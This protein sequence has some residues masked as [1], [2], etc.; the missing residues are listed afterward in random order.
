[1]AKFNKLILLAR[2]TANPEIRNVN[3]DRVAI[4][5]L[6]EMKPGKRNQQTGEWEND[7]NPMYI[8]A[9]VWTSSYSTQLFDVVTQYCQQG[10]AVLVSGYL[11]LEQWQD[12]TTGQNRQRHKLVLQDV[13]LWGSNPNQNQGQPQNGNGTGQRNNQGQPNNRQPQQR[14]GQQRPPAGGGGYRNPPPSGP[15]GYDNDPYNYPPA[16]DPGTDEDIPF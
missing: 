16:G 15:A 5:R 14:G 7:P 11:K 1:M 3:E 4:V 6:A 12:K 8:D 2:L 13:Q 9:E 10:S